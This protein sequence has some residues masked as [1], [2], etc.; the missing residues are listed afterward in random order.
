MSTNR[1]TS[2]AICYGV[3]TSPG[4]PAIL[5]QSMWLTK[6]NRPVSPVRSIFEALIGKLRKRSQ[7]HAPLVEQAQRRALKSKLFSSSQMHE[8]LS[9][10]APIPAKNTARPI[11]TPHT[12]MDTSTPITS[13]AR[14]RSISQSVPGNIRCSSKRRGFAYDNSSR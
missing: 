12:T 14:G 6:G 10:Q 9:H 13:L 1:W 3:S 7:S 2:S 8:N 5:R 11:I 4:R